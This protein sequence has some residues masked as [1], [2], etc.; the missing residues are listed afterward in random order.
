[1]LPGYRLPQ[2]VLLHQRGEL[3]YA[4]AIDVGFTT[5]Y[6]YDPR[7]VKRFLRN[8]LTSDRA[9]D[10]RRREP[11][12]VQKLA[13][14]HGASPDRAHELAKAAIARTELAKRVRVDRAGAKKTGRAERWA[15][16]FDEVQRQIAAERQE[17]EE[18][19]LDLADDGPISD[20]AVAICV[21]ELDCERHPEDW[22]DYR[23]WDKEAK[24]WTLKPKASKAAANRVLTALSRRK[25]DLQNGYT[26]LRVA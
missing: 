19:E 8:R 18:L 2:L 10:V 12:L 26:E 17:Q 4:R 9:W 20:Y 7:A 14:S 25:K 11:V 15:E 21:A 13:A 23:V 5:M 16:M 6:G 1:M 24:V 3:P 22:R